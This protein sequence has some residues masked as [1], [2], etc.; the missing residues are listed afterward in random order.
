MYVRK[1]CMWL[2]WYSG[3]EYSLATPA[4]GVFKNIFSLPYPLPN[5]VIIG[6]IIQSWAQ[7]RYFV[8]RYR[9]SFLATV[10]CL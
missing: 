3:I 6:S 7:N 1:Y 5:D 2:Q 4:A 9:Y 8:T 10:T